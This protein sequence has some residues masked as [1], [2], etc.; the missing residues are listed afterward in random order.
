MNEFA[1]VIAGSSATNVMFLILFGI[2]NYCRKRL[3][4]SECQSHNCLFDCEA[5]LTELQ[6]VKQSVTTQRGMLENVLSILEEKSTQK[7]VMETD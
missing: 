5:Q 3:N 6:H 1:Q 2:L 7:T 4:K